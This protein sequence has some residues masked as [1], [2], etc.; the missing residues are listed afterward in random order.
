[1]PFD[2]YERKR[3]KNVIEFTSYDHLTHQSGAL[4]DIS[5]VERVA[6][7]NDDLG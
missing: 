2:N 5:G 4:A 3:R 6:I 7:E 1:M